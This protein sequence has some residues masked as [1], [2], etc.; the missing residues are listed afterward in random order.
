M[1]FGRARGCCTRAI[2]IAPI[3]RCTNPSACCAMPRRM[4]L[5]PKRRCRDVSAACL[6]TRPRKRRSCLS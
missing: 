4:P 5:D 2:G 6:G 1:E 3:Q